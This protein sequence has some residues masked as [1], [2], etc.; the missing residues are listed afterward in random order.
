MHVCVGKN[1]V[2]MRFDTVYGFRYSLGVLELPLWIREVQG[3]IGRIAVIM[4]M[5]GHWYVNGWR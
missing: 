3:T 4:G 2:C 1:K 5:R